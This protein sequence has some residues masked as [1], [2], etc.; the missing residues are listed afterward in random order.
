MSQFQLLPNHLSMLNVEV[1]DHSLILHST[2]YC[3]KSTD[4]AGGSNENY[5]AMAGC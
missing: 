1:P 2:S 5:G 3:C 4:C